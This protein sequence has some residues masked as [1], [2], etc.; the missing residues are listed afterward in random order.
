MPGT[1]CGVSAGGAAGQ[2][3][4]HPAANKQHS[5]GHLQVLHSSRSC[6]LPQE[7]LLLLWRRQ[8]R[9]L[10]MVVSKPGCRLGS[11]FPLVSSGGKGGSRG[12]GRQHSASCTSSTLC[13]TCWPPWAACCPH[14]ASPPHPP[15]GRPPGASGAAAAGKHAAALPAAAG[16]KEGAP[17]ALP[18]SALWVGKWVGGSVHVG[19]CCW[20]LICNASHI[21]GRVC[22]S[23][24]WYG[25]AFCCTNAVRS[26]GCQLA[27]STRLNFSIPP[28]S[29]GTCSAASPTGGSV[30]W[31]V[32]SGITICSCSACQLHS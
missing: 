8:P 27:S 7:L 30:M 20:T 5:P 26:G 19:R 25:A 14:T 32:S 3:G 11:T 4:Q 13:S 24:W 12:S 21:K 23:D 15:A 31:A 29:A 1:S 28:Q 17:S 18:E 16:W 22:R 10:K 2:A 6:P 9:T